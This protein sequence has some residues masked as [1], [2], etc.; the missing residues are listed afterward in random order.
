MA[1]NTT[2]NPGAGGDVIATD[3]I[4]GVKY[5]RVKV[6]Y[7]GD[8]VATDV[9]ATNP[10]PVAP[11]RASASTSAS[12]AGSTT[13]VTLLALNASRLGATIFNDSTADLYVKLGSTATLTDFTCRLSPNA[14]YEV[15]YGYTGRIDGIWSSA[16]GSA[17]VT[18]VT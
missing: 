18:E 15:P 16:T 1:D 9:S 12:V 14:Y 10:L 8:G 11:S 7:G 4:A 6:N 17:R 3:D 2:L 13:N 5:Q